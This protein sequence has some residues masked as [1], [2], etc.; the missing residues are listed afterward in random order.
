MET[1]TSIIGYEKTPS[2]AHK[3]TFLGNRVAGTFDDEIGALAESLAGQENANPVQVA[4][5]QKDGKLF[6]KGMREILPPAELG[7]PE[8]E[9]AEV[10]Q[11]VEAIRGELAPVDAAKMEAVAPGADTL[12]APVAAVD[13]PTLDAVLTATQPLEAYSA[14]AL[15]AEVGRRLKAVSA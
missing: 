3:I 9:V 4:L 5:E 13:E 11:M 10:E 6:V 2:G 12:A 15:L 1:M 8:D 14:D 7:G